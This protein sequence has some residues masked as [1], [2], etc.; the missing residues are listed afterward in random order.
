MQ[1]PQVQHLITIKDLAQRWNVSGR[2]IT[3]R[4][5]NNELRALKIGK[6]LRFRPEDVTRFEEAALI[7]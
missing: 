1:F 6:N 3:R 7:Q 4:V 2:T 5:K